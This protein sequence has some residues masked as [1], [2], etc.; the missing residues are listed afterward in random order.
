VLVVV[1]EGEALELD[2]RHQL[3]IVDPIPAGFEADSPGLEGSRALDGLGWLGETSAT[4]YTDALDDRFV[5]ALDLERDD[6]RSFRVAYIVRAVTPGDYRLGP[7]F[8]EDMYRP[9]F[10]ARGESGWMHV[11]ARP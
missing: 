3:L 6:S 10:R 7:P 2:Q 11:Q 9:M 1:L 5:A 4:L 8:V